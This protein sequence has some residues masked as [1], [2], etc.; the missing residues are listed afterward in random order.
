[1]HTGGLLIYDTPISGGITISL[2]EHPRNVRYPPA[3]SEPPLVN[4]Q[5]RLFPGGVQGKAVGMWVNR[6]PAKNKRPRQSLGYL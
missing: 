2:S 6:K 5:T 1:M 3:C 4:V